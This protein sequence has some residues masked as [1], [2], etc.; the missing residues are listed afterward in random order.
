MLEAKSI[1]EKVN[2]K[3]LKKGFI[4]TKDALELLI[5]QSGYDR[6]INHLKDRKMVFVSREIVED[7]Y[8]PR[9]EEKRKFE[10]KAEKLPLDKFLKRK[11]PK[12]RRIKAEIEIVRNVSDQY[13]EGKFQDFLELFQD[14]FER[15]S[16]IF[17]MKPSMRDFSTIPTVLKR[18]KR[19]KVKTVGIVTEKRVTSNNNVILTIEDRGEFIKVLVHN[20]WKKLFELA[21]YIVEDEVIGVEGVMG[22]SI[23]FA[24]AVEFPDIPIGRS[25]NKSRKNLSVALISDLHVG[26]KMFLEKAF[27]RFIRWLNLK[28][29]KQM[30]LASTVKYLIIAGDIADGIGIYPN[31][32]EELD[33]DDLIEQYE[34][35]A[36]LLSLVPERI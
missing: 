14:R 3:F 11:R 1:S 28:Y 25:L 5:T 17:R 22:E 31:Q 15:L 21:R 32:R 20:R 24:N 33:I 7:F 29:E 10:F 36:E 13:S 2:E 4:L 26:S 16:R 34:K 23:I 6:F 19:E 9:I 30:E 8:F 12:P 18:R 27:L 35:T